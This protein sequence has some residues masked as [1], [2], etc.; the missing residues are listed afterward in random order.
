MLLDLIRGGRERGSR[1]FIQMNK[2]IK[3]FKLE[4]KKCKQNESEEI[5]KSIEEKY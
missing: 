3:K 2:S 1:E 4:R 5:S